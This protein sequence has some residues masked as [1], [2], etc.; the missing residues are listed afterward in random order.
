[1][2]ASEDALKVYA[3]FAGVSVDVARQIRQEFDPKEMVQP[4]QVMGLDDLMADAVRFKYI[5]QPLTPEQLR[6]LVQIR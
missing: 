4:D 1:M 6:E 2:Y 3:E 5:G